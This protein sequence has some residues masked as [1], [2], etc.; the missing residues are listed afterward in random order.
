MKKARHGKM[1]EEM[2]GD[3]VVTTLGPKEKQE[4]YEKS[5]QVI[6]KVKEC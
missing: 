2:E 6:S 3:E 1:Y 5:A 4:F